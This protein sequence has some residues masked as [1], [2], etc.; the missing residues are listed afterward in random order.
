MLASVPIE[1]KS[2]RD[3][4][5]Q[6]WPHK[7]TR[8]AA[9]SSDYSSIYF[10]FSDN[11]LLCTSTL[12]DRKPVGAPLSQPKS[13]ISG[14]LN[15]DQIS[16]ISDLNTNSFQSLGFLIEN[17]LTNQ[18]NLVLHTA[19]SKESSI[20]EWITDSE[21]NVLFLG[22]I[23]KQSKESVMN[24]VKSVL[25]A[26]NTSDSFSIILEG[27][28][29]KNKNIRYL[30]VDSKGNK[31]LSRDLTSFPEDVV[32]GESSL[33]FINEQG[34][35]GLTFNLNYGIVGQS[36]SIPSASGGSNSSDKWYFVSAAHGELVLLHFSSA[37]AG[38]KSLVHRVTIEFSE[39]SEK[40]SL[41]SSLG[42]VSLVKPTAASQKPGPITTSLPATVASQIQNNL[43][44]YYDKIFIDEKQYD[45]NLLKHYQAHSKA[46]RTKAFFVNLESS[47]IT[48][49]NQPLSCF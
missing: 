28:E 15:K 18:L 27:S 45:S 22:T 30:K 1:S 38:S 11:T 36:F 32:V 20:S 16:L 46:M 42:A 17:R 39:I 23:G 5:V 26:N 2:A 31:L 47:I 19:K 4:H 21:V 3:Y 6:P 12:K 10:I 41:F 35:S 37:A 44:K 24:V 34:T 49:S 9:L 8:L 25:R 7:V 48:V 14:K 33:Y 43:S 29:N 40:G 13:F